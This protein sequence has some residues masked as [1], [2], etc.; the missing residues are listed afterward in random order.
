VRSC[1][2]PK[3]PDNDRDDRRRRSRRAQPNNQ[4]EGIKMKNDRKSSQ[5][6]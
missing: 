5:V 6:Y 1:F 2:L 4:A 3:N